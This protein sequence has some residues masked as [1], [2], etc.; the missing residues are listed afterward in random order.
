M[1]EPEGASTDRATW[2]AEGRAA[3]LF[4]LSTDPKAESRGWGAVQ[5]SGSKGFEPVDVLNLAPQ[6]GGAETGLRSFCGAQCRLDKFSDGV[7]ALQ[8][9]AFRVGFA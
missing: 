8:R 6:T 7:S 5:D 3:W 2:G 9:L 4:T 1:G